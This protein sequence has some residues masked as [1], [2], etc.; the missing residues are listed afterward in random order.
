MRTIGLVEEKKDT[1]KNNAE[2]VAKKD[3]KNIKKET[4][5]E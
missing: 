3:V 2:E 5:E 1:K 4:S